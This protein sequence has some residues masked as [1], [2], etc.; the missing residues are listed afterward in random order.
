[1]STTAAG[2]IITGAMAYADQYPSQAGLG[3]AHA[4]LRLYEL[5]KQQE[6]LTHQVR[7]YEAIETQLKPLVCGECDGRGK[8]NRARP[9]GDGTM[10]VNCSRCMGSGKP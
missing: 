10:S 3:L 1:M 6:V 9:D 7:V 2:L 4:R 5:R 8:V